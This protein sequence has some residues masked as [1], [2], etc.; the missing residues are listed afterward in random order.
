MEFINAAATYGTFGVVY[1]NTPFHK[2]SAEELSALSVSAICDDNSELF[3]WTDS[4]RVADV[5]SI[6][7]AWG[8][9]AGSIEYVLDMTP[10][11]PVDGKRC[12]GVQ[13]LPWWGEA[14]ATGVVHPS[15]EFL[16]HFVKGNGAPRISK[17]KQ[18]RKP[19]VSVPEFARKTDKMRRPAKIPNA[20]SFCTRPPVFLDSIAERVDA[21]IL[22]LFGH[23]VRPN[24]FGAGPCIPSGFAPALVSKDGAAG[25]VNAFADKRGKVALKT[26][27]TRLA[28][29]DDEHMLVKDFKAAA[30]DVPVELSI[31]ILQHRV[32]TYPQ[33]RK[34]KQVKSEKP[35]GRFGIASP[36]VVSQDLLD[37]MGL[38]PGTMVA[39]T[40][41][42]KAINAY[43]TAN[44]LK[45][46]RFVVMDEKLTKL[47]QPPEGK[48][49][50]FFELCKLLSRSFPKK[51]VLDTDE[52]AAKKQKVA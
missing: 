33:R 7:S 43:I 6:A 24:V 15:L 10:A 14:R 13:S 30:P 51:A 12:R 28:A 50:S 35:R 48:S 16:M 29:G 17:V 20:D 8:F 25:V 49:T 37:F 38:E 19:V 46:G 4:T 3:M 2:M 23:E 11:D 45:N 32:K 22:E 34:R 27:A 44:N 47:L 39:R 40:T 41:A 52:S 26:L 31:A 42:V 21:K 36:S 1:V 5:A 18:D 9:G